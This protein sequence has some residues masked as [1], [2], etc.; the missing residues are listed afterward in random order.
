MSERGIQIRLG[1]HPRFALSELCEITDIP[2]KSKN[3]F[4]RAP[5]T[6]ESF[7]ITLGIQRRNLPSHLLHSLEF[8]TLSIATKRGRNYSP[9]RR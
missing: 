4:I 3:E 5:R 6:S 2:H 8:H 1:S 7:D 9:P